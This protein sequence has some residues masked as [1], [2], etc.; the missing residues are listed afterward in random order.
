M[1]SAGQAQA[2]NAVLK[3]AAAVVV[4]VVADRGNCSDGCSVPAPT[5]APTFIVPPALQ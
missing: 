4:T 5:I 2:S 3:V 1:V